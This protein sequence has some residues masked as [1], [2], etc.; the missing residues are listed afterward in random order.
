MDC[1]PESDSARGNG[2][3]KHCEKRVR[4]R[5]V[6]VHFGH[7]RIARLKPYSVRT[8]QMKERAPCSSPCSWPPTPR[9]ANI[10]AFLL[11]IL[12]SNLGVSYPLN[13]KGA[14]VHLPR[15]VKVVSYDHLRMIRRVVWLDNPRMIRRDSR[16]WRSRSPQQG[17]E[18][19]A[20]KRRR[21]GNQDYCAGQLQL[22]T[23]HGKAANRKGR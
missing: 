2:R 14:H 1:A 11:A 9:F 12:L 10:A 18:S 4:L 6:P 13:R 15:R 22:L 7:S 3:R 17:A 20:G 16:T 23:D 5:N 21:Q 8:A 19:N